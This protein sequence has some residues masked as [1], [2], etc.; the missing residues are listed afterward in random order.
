[1]AKNGN[2]GAPFAMLARPEK[3]TGL[4]FFE[5]CGEQFWREASSHSSRPLLSG[6]RGSAHGSGAARTFE[7]PMNSALKRTLRQSR[8]AKR[9]RGTLF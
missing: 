7:L 9:S 4:A 3:R 1:M 2:E 5:A 8:S 6:K